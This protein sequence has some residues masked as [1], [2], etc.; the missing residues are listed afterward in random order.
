M[1]AYIRKEKE[2]GVS[3]VIATILMVAI[4][5]VLAATLYLMVGNMGGTGD[6]TEPIQFTASKVGTSTWTLQ[7]SSNDLNPLE[8]KFALQKT[9]G[10]YAISGAS[11]PAS[12]GA[13]GAVN[14]T[15][16]TND[17]VV[18]TWNDLNGDGSVNTGDSITIEGTGSASSIAS[19][20]NFAI[21]AGATGNVKLP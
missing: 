2:E 19:G 20:W 7:V 9:D 4:T 5:V 12:S 13:A 16:G 3:P 11:F 21:T 14:T 1:K 6:V 8:M 15:V 18:V 17:Y 10:S